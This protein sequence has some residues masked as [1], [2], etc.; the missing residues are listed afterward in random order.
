MQKTHGQGLLSDTSF[1][2]YIP[3]LRNW[4]SQEGKQCCVPGPKSLT[5]SLGSV[6]AHEPQTTP[7]QLQKVIKNNSKQNSLN[8]PYRKL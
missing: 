3:C 1:A 6:D 7:M 2:F 8:W 5:F 4:L